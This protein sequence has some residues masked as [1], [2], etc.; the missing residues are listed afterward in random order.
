MIVIGLRQITSKRTAAS[1]APPII[2]FAARS[3]V[4]RGRGEKI[5][6]GTSVSHMVVA[7]DSKTTRPPGNLPYTVFL[8]SNSV[9][10]RNE[11]T[12]SNK[13]ASKTI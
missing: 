11:F 4:R 12:Q 3:L 8:A 10:V 1:H 7:N 6:S 5:Y 13:F 2:S 9:I